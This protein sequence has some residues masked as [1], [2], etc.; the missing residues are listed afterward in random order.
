MKTNEDRNAIGVLWG[1]LEFLEIIDVPMLQSHTLNLDTACQ[2]L[3]AVIQPC[4]MGG[5]DATHELATY[6]ESTVRVIVDLHTVKCVVG[7]VKRS[8]EWGIIDHSGDF[9]RT[10]FLNPEI[11]ID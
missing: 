11:D 5:K 8:N 3:L 10:V 1:R 4:S 9:A 2:Y 7:R 6:S